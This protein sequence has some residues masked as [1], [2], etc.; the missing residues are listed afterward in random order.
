MTNLDGRQGLQHPFDFVEEGAGVVVPE[1]EWEDVAR[2]LFCWEAMDLHAI[3][4]VIPAIP[5]HKNENIPLS[6]SNL[7]LAL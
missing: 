3:D 4:F 1:E 5:R 2:Q 7:D 6:T